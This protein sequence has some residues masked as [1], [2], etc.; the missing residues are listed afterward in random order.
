MKR[1]LL[2]LLCAFGVSACG[3]KLRS[4]AMLPQGLQRLYVSS[5]VTYSQVLPRL[6]SILRAAGVN[7]VR[8]AKMAPYHLIILSEHFATSQ[9]SQ[10][11]GSQLI[12][13]TTGF[14]LSYQ[15]V[16]QQGQIVFGPLQVHATEKILADS[17]QMQSTKTAEADLKNSLLQQSLS[18]VMNQL[19]SP[20]ARKQLAK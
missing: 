3:F 17:N 6:R 9:S 1:L 14:Y 2:T 4:Q 12:T 5:Q 11:N 13:A 10:T 8:Q 20:N 16:D 15:I 19:T 18:Q 7:L